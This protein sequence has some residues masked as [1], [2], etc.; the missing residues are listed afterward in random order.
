M[1]RNAILIFEL[2]Q[3]SQFD[4][5]KTSL[6]F[7]LGPNIEFRHSKSYLDIKTWSEY[8]I[9]TSNSGRISQFDNFNSYFNVR[10][11]T[12]SF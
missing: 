5:Q 4:I 9:L 10:I 7:E 3:I 6:T 12:D 8:F 11:R 2:G 1:M